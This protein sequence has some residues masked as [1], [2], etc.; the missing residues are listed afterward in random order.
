MGSVARIEPRARENFTHSL[1]MIIALASWAMM[2]GALFFVYAGVRTSARMWPPPGMPAL[3]V[4]L[5]LLNT[6]VLL[7][8]SASLFMGTRALLRGD[9]KSLPR[10]VAGAMVLGAAFLGLQLKMWRDLWVT[11]ML[12]SSGIYASVFYGL[13][14]LHALHVAAGLLVLGVV[15]VRALKGTYTE[16]NA[17]RVR[18]AGMFWHF[19]DV[20]WVFMFVALYLL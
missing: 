9:R 10:W 11:G 14:V 15:L 16:H 13:T 8:S 18:V 6:L 4:L 2:F 17:V 7:A 1:G 12:P 3:P 20:V 19:V 5:P